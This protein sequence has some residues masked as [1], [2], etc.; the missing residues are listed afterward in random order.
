MKRPLVFVALFYT[1]GLLLAAAWHPPVWILFSVALATAIASLLWAQARS[2]LL[3]ALLVLTGWANLAARTAIISPH[4]LQLVLGETPRD[5]TVRG[6]LLESPSQ[7]IYVR[8]DKE[9]WRSFARVKVTQLGTR[10][11]WQPA[12]GRI[13]A[14]THGMLSDD[15]F[16]GQPVEISGV[17]AAPPGAVT[18]GLFD[19]RAY[20]NH[21]SI[22][23]QLN[24][25]SSNDWH[26]LST[27][28]TPPLGDRFL[29]WAKVTLARGL[30]VQDQSLK[31]LWAMTL[32]WK[33]GL[34]NE[35]SEPFM[36]SGTMHIFAISGL[37]IALIAALLVALLRVLQVPRSGC[38]FIVIP[39]IWFYTA[40]TGWQP[41]AIRSTVMMTVVIGGWAL[42]RP[43]DLLNSLA[44]SAFIILLWDP[45]QL[46]GASF[47]LS[48]FVVLSIA[49]LVPPLDALRDRWLQTEPLLPEQLVAG[50]RR[51][52]RLPVRWLTTS[53]ATSIAAWIGSLPLTAYYFHL[54]SPVTLLAN[55][56]IVPLSTAALACNLGSL[57]CGPWFPF[58]SEYFNHSAWW[59]MQCMVWFSDWSTQ[60]PSSYFYVRSPSIADFI[61]FYLLLVVALSGWLFAKTH[62]FRGAIIILL[63]ALFY[64]CEWRLATRKLQLTIL[65][66]GSGTAIYSEAPHPAGKL[67]IDCGSSTAAQFTSRPFLRARG[68]NHLPTLLLTHADIQHAGGAPLL[69]E[70][71][72]IN[73][74]LVSPARFQSS[75]YKKMLETLR[76]KPNLVQTISQGATISSWTLLHPT[77]LTNFPRADD[78]AIVLQ[79]D[80]HR[81]RLLLLSDLG[82]LGQEALI[83]RHPKLRADIVVTGLPA[84]EQPLCEALLDLLQPQLI[85]ITDD[86]FPHAAQAKPQLAE[87]LSRRHVPVIYTAVAGAVTIE[88]GEN[89]WR[90]HSIKGTQLRGQPRPYAT[91][92]SLPRPTAPLTNSR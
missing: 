26:R 51:W 27:S 52:T 6:T 70:S 30:P 92:N 87:R 67:L 28:S 19:Y 10:D 45:Q 78:N 36:R 54:F 83:E 59:W 80:F 79:G 46:F 69:V 89:F 39:L 13:I 37:H 18:E 32:G 4:D 11:S 12:E 68:I 91:P 82:R 7:R 43:S 1:A 17:I 42:E 60:L 41:S 76:Q 16:A 14:T 85:I 81:T 50:W 38:G 73:Q 44:A 3:A 57:I 84:Q 47:Q 90:L 31:L 75:P 65:P 63:A 5:V 71:F 88:F 15:F 29:A 21:E 58:L 9:L 34:T 49:L 25:N 24:S 33:T 40:A 2:W 62:R 48:F 35:V 55:L 72:Q 77:T 8:D 74:V 56:V 22:H 53:L 66:L 64:F 20:L 61:L 86:N 23:Y